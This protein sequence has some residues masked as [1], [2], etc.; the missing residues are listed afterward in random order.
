MSDLA[1]KCRKTTTLETAATVK[2]ASPLPLKAV[3]KEADE[4]T[5]QNAIEAAQA[6]L[7][8][9]RL[10]SPLQD[11]IQQD[12]KTASV[13]IQKQIISLHKAF[14]AVTSWC[15]DMLNNHNTNNKVLLDM[16]LQLNRRAH[17]LQLPFHMPLYSRLM[18]N[19]AQHYDPN[20]VIS[21]SNPQ[22]RN[23]P[24]AADL[25][26]EIAGR[27]TTM[28]GPDAISSQVFRD[29]LETLTRRRQFGDV[30]AILTRL[31]NNTDEF[32]N[33]LEI[34]K[35]TL[36]RVLFTLEFTLRQDNATD[37]WEK[38]ADVLE[39]LN[40]ADP[41]LWKTLTPLTSLS[42]VWNR[43]RERE[44]QV[45]TVLEQENDGEEEQQTDKLLPTRPSAKGES[46]TTRR[47]RKRSLDSYKKKDDLYLFRG[48]IYQSESPSEH[49]V[50]PD[51]TSQIEALYDGK[52]F[53]YSEELERSIL[54]RNMD[55]DDDD[56]D[57][58]VDDLMHF[59]D[60]TDYSDDEDLF[61]VSDDDDSD[62]DE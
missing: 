12:P 56:V 48:W 15:L 60:D 45:R 34:D 36:L 49:D 61:D 21:N 17:Q 16:A 42:E 26:L 53:R 20:N 25:V 22:P 24:T 57:M 14:L 23:K 18:T 13:D 47:R 50:L 6:L 10:A 1:K 51:I 4:A 27:V 35:G 58:N 39:I 59:D 54:K 33:I 2:Q 37:N 62:E 7:F 52:D 30:V 5:I 31:E 38:T 28:L 19:V 3:T 46:S 8:V 29:P 32:R 11:A 40:L 43:K 41:Y 44:E 55:D 9:T